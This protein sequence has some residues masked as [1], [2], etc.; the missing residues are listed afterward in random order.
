MVEVAKRG[1]D[2][3]YHIP[4]LYFLPNLTA[5][6][7]SSR[8]NQ[9]NS[10]CLS[11]PILLL[12][13]W[14]SNSKEIL[15]QTRR[16]LCMLSQDSAE[17]VYDKFQTELLLQWLSADSY[18]IRDAQLLENTTS[19]S[20]ETLKSALSPWRSLRRGNHH[21]FFPRLHETSLFPHREHCSS[22]LKNVE[23]SVMGFECPP[24]R[25]PY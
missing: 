13:R 18:T 6:R 8:D 2:Q 9:Q 20:T 15:W 14:Y 17:L 10:Q 4:S 3:K 1:S 5:D 11:T 16:E 23:S 22:Q 19:A 7:Q 24:R 21:V 12:S 25:E